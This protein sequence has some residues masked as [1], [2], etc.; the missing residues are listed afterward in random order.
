M[1]QRKYSKQHCKATK[2]SK[3]IILPI[4]LSSYNE[5]SQEAKAF[6]AWL[7]TMIANYPE[8]FPADIEIGY[9]LHDILPPS[10]KMPDVQLR[11]IQLKAQDEN[12]C[13]PV[14][15][16]ASSEVLPYMT[17]YTDEVEKPLFLRRFSVPFWSVLQKSV[18]GEFRWAW[19]NSLNPLK[20]RKINDQIGEKT[21][22]NLVRRSAR[23]FFRG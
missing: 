19:R 7:D 6:R 20:A 22:I 13:R 9:T 10:V 18:Q 5:L 1:P 4:E 15:T 2:V 14:F 23:P 3:R 21:V 12:G 16:I 11:R 17:G 8:L